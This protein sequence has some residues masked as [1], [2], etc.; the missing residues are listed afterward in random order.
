MTTEEAVEFCEGDLACGGFTFYGTNKNSEK[1]F[2]FF[3]HYIPVNKWGIISENK[4]DPIGNT[5]PMPLWT[6][7]RSR[8]KVLVLPGKSHLRKIKHPVKMDEKILKN[9]ENKPWSFSEKIVSVSYSDTEVSGQ[10]NFNLQ[11]HDFKATGWTTFLAY[12]EIHT[13]KA[14]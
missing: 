6:S 8:K 13:S 11:D 9:I 12:D 4:K 2:M 14:E 7:Y 1:H 10:I 5:V 3:V